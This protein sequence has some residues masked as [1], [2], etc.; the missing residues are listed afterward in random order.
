MRLLLGG[1]IL[2][3]VDSVSIIG[4]ENRNLE[5][6]K[7]YSLY[8][9]YPNPFN[10]ITKIMFDI[11]PLRGGREMITKLFVYD[12]L[13]REVAILVN[14]EQKPGKFKVEW[15]A[16]NYPSGV[17]FYRLTVGDPSASSGSSFTQTK[18]MVLIK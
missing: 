15:D 3:L 18:K 9:N 2:R 4:I 17:Y 14:Q 10:P 11:P 1:R 16:S 12:V 8:Q 7:S 6:P 5:F 13:G